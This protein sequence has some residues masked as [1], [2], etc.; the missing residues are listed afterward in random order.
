[1]RSSISPEFATAIASLGSATT[2][3]RLL[4]VATMVSLV[5]VL[6]V[7]EALSTT[8]ATIATALVVA[9][10]VVTLLIALIVV[11]VA[12]FLLLS[13]KAWATSHLALLLLAPVVIPLIVSLREVLV[14]SLH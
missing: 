2:L 11:I 1:M 4:E 12:A 8:A 5:V 7:V 13:S 9:R 6:G 14:R 10:A 3:L